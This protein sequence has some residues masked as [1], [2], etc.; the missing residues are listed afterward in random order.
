MEDN[1]SPGNDGLTKEFYTAFWTETKN[2]FLASVQAASVKGELSSSQRQA[3]IKLTEKEDRDKRLIK[4][5]R[6]ISL[7]N[8]DMKLI[9]KVLATRLKKV[10]PSLISPNQTA[11]VENRFIGESGRLISDML[12]ITKTLKKEG[13]LITID[14]EKAFDS[15]DHNFLLTS[16][17]KY[18][19]GE[20]F[21]SWIKTILKNQESCIING[22]TTTKYFNLERG[23]RQGDPISAYLFILVLEFFFSNS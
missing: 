10:L 8:I 16:L 6:P 1:K 14:I 9:T 19:F 18:G 7:L 2:P 15:V 11:Y 3:V 5:W 23:T 13:F 21:L 4:N 22:G 12:E 17:D 20:Q